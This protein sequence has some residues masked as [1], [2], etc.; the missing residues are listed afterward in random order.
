M[1][2]KQRK[3]RQDEIAHTENEIV[4]SVGTV[5]SLNCRNMEMIPSYSS[6]DVSVMHSLLSTFT[7][8]MFIG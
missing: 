1:A 4:L 5:S 7:A 2:R 8:V 3:Q 6:V